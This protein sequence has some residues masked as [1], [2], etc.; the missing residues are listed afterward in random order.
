MLTH[1]IGRINHEKTEELDRALVM[2]L[3]LHDYAWDQPAIPA[4]GPEPPA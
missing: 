3:D 4:L 1:F 2:A